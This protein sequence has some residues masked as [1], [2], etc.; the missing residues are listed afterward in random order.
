MVGL[1]CL[2]VY[3]SLFNTAEKISKFELHTKNFDEISFT[4][5]KDKVAEIPGVSD[6]SS[7]DLKHEIH[8]TKSIKTRRKPVTE[9]S[10]THG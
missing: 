7:E 3:N 5:L 1:A 9:K 10:Q 8:G 4:N 2:E 6:I